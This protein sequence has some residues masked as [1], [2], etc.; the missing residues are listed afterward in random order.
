MAH[1]VSLVGQG[2][3]AGVYAASSIFRL[4]RSSQ[5]CAR[6]SSVPDSLPRQNTRNGGR[7][8]GSVCSAGACAGWCLGQQGTLFVAG[9][10]RFP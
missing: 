7:T 6:R 1:S 3:R 5:A 8:A 9:L 2:A 10:A 4:V